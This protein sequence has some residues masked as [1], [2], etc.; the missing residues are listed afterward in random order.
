MRHDP[1]TADEEE[2]VENLFNCLCSS[3]FLSKKNCQL[4][5]QAE[6]IELMILIL[7]EKRKK[8][9]S[10]DVRVSALKLLSHC[11]SI[12]PHDGLLQSTC[13]KFVEIFG[14]R[15]LMPIYLKPSSIIGQKRKRKQSLIDQVEEHSLSII[16]A[17]L[18][19]CESDK[20]NRVLNKF[21]ENNFV[22]TERLIELHFKYYERL[23]QCDN[24]IK[25][26]GY[27]LNQ[28]EMREMLFL[29]RFNDG[30]LFTLQL[31]DQIMILIGTDQ[32]VIENGNDS[33]CNNLIK[34]HI[35]KLL[36]M[37]KTSS[38][39]VDHMNIIR[40]IVK[41]YAEEKSELERQRLINLIEIF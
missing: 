20:K 12:D 10:T 18:S 31:I 6:G 35:M 9:S 37:H 17:L 4:F 21:V 32:T 1:L 33:R 41:E 13:D 14:L 40:N 19:F 16:L 2:F 29:R 27:N 24:K 23:N 5:F 36:N 38:S 34:S 26:D 22:K 25:V 11:F 39:N 28:P 8:V 30:G 3:L 7:K 15:V